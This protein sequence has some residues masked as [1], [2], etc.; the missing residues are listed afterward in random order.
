MANSRS[1]ASLSPNGRWPAISGRIRR[2]GDP[3]QAWLAFLQ[4]HREVIVAFDFF[5]APRWL[6]C[7]REQ[8]RGLRPAPAAPSSWGT[9][10]VPPEPEVCVVKTQRWLSLIH[11]SE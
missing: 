8:L 10:R 3:G 5:T 2:R 11:I 7:A 4:N 6:W 9:G 1:L